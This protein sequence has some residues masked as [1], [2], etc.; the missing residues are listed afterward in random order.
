MTAPT[1]GAQPVR[2]RVLV[3]GKL[4][5][6]GRGIDIDEQGEGTVSEPRLYQL[7]RQKNKGIPR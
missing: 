4:P 1:T 6:Q 5:G 7:I 3:D 2:F